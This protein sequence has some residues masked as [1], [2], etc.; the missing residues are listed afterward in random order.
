[1]PDVKKKKDDGADKLIEEETAE[2]GNV[3]HIF[4]KIRF[5]CLRVTFNGIR[6]A[7]SPIIVSFRQIK[8]S[9][10]FSYVKSLGVVAAV[11]TIL[12]YVLHNVATVYSNIWLSGECFFQLVLSS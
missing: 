7:Q 4:V 1:M 2:I 9:V 12:G 6:A 3:N 10:V 8:A 5:S 11:A